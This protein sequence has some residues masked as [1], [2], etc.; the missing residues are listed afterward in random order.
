MKRVVVTGGAGFIGS[1][2]AEALLSRG[3]EV[4]IVD[5]LSTGLKQ[6]VADI[7]KSSG[8]SAQTVYGD[9]SSQNVQQSI[10]EFKPEFIFHLAAQANVRRSV[11][12]PDFDASSNVIG[13]IRLLET[14]RRVPVKGII[15]SSTGGAIY[16]E[17]ESFPAD[18]QHRTSPE[19]PYGV[20]KRAGELYLEYYARTFNF[21]A[22]VLRYA[23]VFGPRQNPEGEAGVVAIFADRLMQGGDLVVYGD[24]GQTRDF[25]HVS[26]VVQANILAAEALDSGKLKP[27]RNFTIF[28]VG[29]A[30]EISVNQV[31]DAMRVA[32]SESA[33]IADAGASQLVVTNAPPRLGE[34]RRSVV[35]TRKIERELGWRAK[36]GF[37]QGLISTIRTIRGSNSK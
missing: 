33:S 24:G 32:W 36:I 34:Q 8:K 22:V 18:E 27:E 11:E 10:L 3:C 4:L 16:G 2:V 17:Q 35:D 7:E 12:E 20:S 23:N 29:C 21:P 14:S 31:V 15:F 6:N 1:H 26:D 28:N 19:C 13:V 25:V 30:K 37:E 5:D 9:I